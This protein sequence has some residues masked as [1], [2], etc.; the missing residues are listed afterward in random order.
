MT[1]APRPVPA[2]VNGWSGAYLEEQ[3]QRYLSDPGSVDA[4]TRAFFQGFD[5]AMAGDLR[6][7]PGAGQGT[8]AAS[9]SG[10]KLR[11]LPGGEPASNGAAPARPAPAPA[12]PP[13]PPAAP[14]RRDPQERI[15]ITPGRGQAAG[16]ASHFQAVVDDLIGT[17]RDQGHLAAKID[18]FNYERPRPRGLKLDSHNLGDSDLDR[19]VDAEGLGFSG[20]VPLR[21]VIEKLEDTYCGTIGVEFS[22][23]QDD[24][25]RAW[26][27][28]RFERAGGRLDMG[29]GER[30][31]ILELLT[32][33]ALFERFLGKRY[34]GEKRFSLEGSESLIPLL[35]RTMEAA[36][37]LGVEEIVLGMA[38]R[39]RLSVLNTVLGK[40]YEQIFTEFE[41]SW[42]EDF[43][44]GGGDVKY[45]RGYSGTRRFRNGRMLH[46]AM[47][48]N[49]SHLEAVN[50][51][52]E[53][54]CR[55][56]QRLRADVERSR[57]I[58][59]LV[60][61]DAA[62]SGQGVVA[63]CL[64]FSELEGYTT[65]GTV[66]IVVNNHIGFTTLPRD[67]RSSRYCTDI[68][69]AIDAPIFHVNGEDPEAVV[70]VAQFAM[71]YRQE[72]RKDVFVDLQ[73]YRKYGHNEQDEASFTQPIH[74]RL[75]REK[76]SVLK[77]YSDRL[78][79]LEVINQAD[80][81]AIKL[82]LDESLEK[83]QKAVKSK[84]DDPTIDPGSARWSGLG[85]AFTF[86]PGETAVSMELLSE[87]SASLGRVPDGFNLNR[88]L[89]PLLDARAK[90]SE[91]GEISYADAES[92]AYGTLLLEGHPIRLSGQDSRRGTFSH[93]HA[94]LRDAESG[95]AY[96]P[97]NAMR[98]MGVPGTD[99]APGTVGEDGRPRQARF[100]I[101]D[102]PL[103]EASVLGFDYGYS[104]ADP[105]MLVLWEAQFG[106]FVNGA[107]VH[108]DQFVASAEQK[109]QR[110][111]GLVMLL[112]HGYEGQ[113]PEH[114]SARLE[115]F[116]KL[117]GGNNIQICYP[118]TAAQAFHMLRRQLKR[119]FRKPLIVMTPKSMLR[120]TTSHISELTSGRFREMLDDPRFESGEADRSGVSRVVLCSGKLYYELAA[121]RDDIARDDIAIVRIEQFYP[122]HHEML[123]EVL[124]RYPDDAERVYAQEEPRNMGGYLF[125]AD[126]MMT[127]LGEVRPRYIGRASSASPAVGAKKVHKREQ[128]QVISTAIGPKPEQSSEKGRAEKG[129]AEKAKAG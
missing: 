9:A 129:Q 102:S 118:S 39:G 49:P 121:R 90:L 16:V 98:E 116:L 94:L 60:H 59:V 117:A 33:V 72:F 37:D 8:G 64:N 54:R 115:R 67:G 11:P 71:E 81:E 78:L 91:S 66:H 4:E 109:W 111:S 40:S 114:S 3:Y 107:Q 24:D 36:T 28:E 86:E 29:R 34:P 58:P 104:L 42:L 65:G 125:V 35:D 92:L 126:Q 119:T 83:A 14:A 2:S 76:E 122:F 74:A 52:V 12:A 7:S 1:A 10:S 68:G 105:N 73:C 55:A 96:V 62:I 44:D 31:H 80:I 123:A 82:R 18:P 26:C 120:T 17:Y 6:M 124:G 15:R 93:R 25:R 22:H 57:V 45:H 46:L 5:L 19:P 113:G 84:P 48:S 61:G 27:V 63:E 95:E 108:I 21:Q 97:L 79:E 128:E 75:I 23:I 112:P 53:G 77:R 85:Q 50:P 43:A 87:V 38:H 100:C 20:E 110:W 127:K 30:A 51:V 41:E 69:K 70:A 106:D 88:K 99:K 89:K 103:S 101:Y 56:K 47:A 32:K 13:P